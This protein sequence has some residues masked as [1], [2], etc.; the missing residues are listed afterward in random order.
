MINPPMTC[1]TLN[2]LQSGQTQNTQSKN[3]QPCI[4][5]G[6]FLVPKIVHF[7]LSQPVLGVHFIAISRNLLLALS[8]VYPLLV[9]AAKHSHI[10]IYAFSNLQ[11]ICS[12]MVPKKYF[13]LF[14]AICT[15]LNCTFWCKVLFSKKNPL[16][17]TIFVSNVREKQLCICFGPFLVP[18]P[19]ILLFRNLYFD[20][21]VCTS[22]P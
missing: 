5:F 22:L 6:P 8:F 9:G 13:G 1:L 20:Y 15:W 10:C 3:K 16:I 17:A 12:I 2:R 18:K 19:C 7:T 21:L 14:L 11:Q 4:C